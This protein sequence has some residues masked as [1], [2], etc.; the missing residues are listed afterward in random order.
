MMRDREY[1]SKVKMY[2]DN[3]FKINKR[4]K[5]CVL[6]EEL[7]TYYVNRKGYNNSWNFKDY[8][9]FFYYPQYKKFIRE[10]IHK[11]DLILE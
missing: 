7:R 2:L 8:V 11:I 6:P 1:I 4:D 3:F 10:N 5:V 9:E